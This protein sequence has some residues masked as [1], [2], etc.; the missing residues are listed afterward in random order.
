MA[1]GVT[2][3]NFHSRYPAR[4][5]GNIVTIPTREPTGEFFPPPLGKGLTCATFILAVLRG[6]GLLPVDE[7]TW[8]PRAEDVDWQTAIIEDLEASG[9]EQDHI[10]AV[11]NDIGAKRFRPA[12]V[13]GAVI[14][15]D[16]HWPVRREECFPWIA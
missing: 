15:A 7:T 14:E 6:H 16:S 11:R 2:T 8:L 9:A 12:E 3:C 1:D 13:V 4:R 5:P 10:E